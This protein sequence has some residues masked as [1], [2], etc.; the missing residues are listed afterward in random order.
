MGLKDELVKG[1]VKAAVKSGAAGKIVTNELKKKAE[2]TGNSVLIAAANS[3]TA[4][5]ATKKVLESVADNDSA[6]NLALKLMEKKK[7]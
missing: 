6:L 4:E 7:K 3:K 5:K 1:A 2:Q